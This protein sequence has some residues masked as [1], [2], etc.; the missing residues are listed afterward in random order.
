MYTTVVLAIEIKNFSIG[1]GTKYI[2]DSEVG[3]L[4]SGDTSVMYSSNIGDFS[5]CIRNIELYR[6]FDAL[7]SPN[8]KSLKN[9]L[10]V[11]YGKKFK[12]K[13][14]NELKLALEL[15][16]LLIN[17][18][19]IGSTEKDYSLFRKLNIGLDFK[20]SNNKN[21]FYLRAGIKN[22]FPTFGL[23]YI[24]KDIFQISYAFTNT[25]LGNEFGKE[26]RIINL[27]SVSLNFSVDKNN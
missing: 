19:Y 27:L 10:R 26:R 3:S 18:I 12:I 23:S 13:F 5:L 2:L 15:N 11:G 20:K 22:L 7:I 8:T 16:N 17:S 6:F 24:F 1:I 21:H 9:E 14:F 25:D 4:L